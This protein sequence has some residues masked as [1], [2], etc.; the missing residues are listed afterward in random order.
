MISALW[1]APLKVD[2]W[3]LLWGSWDARYQCRWSEKWLI[4]SVRTTWLMIS[5]ALSLIGSIHLI[6]IIDKT[7]I[8]W[9]CIICGT[10]IECINLPLTSDAYTGLDSKQLPEA[11]VG[12]KVI[13]TVIATVTGRIATNDCEWLKRLPCR[14]PSFYNCHCPN[15]HSKSI[16]HI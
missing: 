11:G 8:I 4:R 7:S 6:F 2:R 9:I 1:Y 12:I 16:S 3:K 13:A 14:V 15:L 10:S 5:F